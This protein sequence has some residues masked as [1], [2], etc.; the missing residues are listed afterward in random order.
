MDECLNKFQNVLKL[1][2]NAEVTVSSYDLIKG[3]NLSY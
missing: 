3:L 1:F 2:E